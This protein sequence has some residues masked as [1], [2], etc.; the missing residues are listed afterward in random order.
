L[1]L[2]RVLC[3]AVEI[4]S[5]GESTVTLHMAAGVAVPAPA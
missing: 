2:A 5:E 1:W 3:D 4:R